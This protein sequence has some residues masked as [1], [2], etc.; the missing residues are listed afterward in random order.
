MPKSVDE[1]VGRIKRRTKNARRTIARVGDSFARTAQKKSI[2]P[3][4]LARATGKF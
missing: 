4:L 1:N 3:A 2:L